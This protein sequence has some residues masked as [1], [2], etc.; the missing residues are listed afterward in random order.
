MGP[1]V[2][3]RPD[4]DGLTATAGGAAGPCYSRRVR[5]P[6]ARSPDAELMDAATPALLRD[7]RAETTRALLVRLWREHIR[8]HRRHLLVILMLTLVMAGSPRSIRW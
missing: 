1:A 3:A 4:R 7:T 8:H 5:N 6:G 2:R